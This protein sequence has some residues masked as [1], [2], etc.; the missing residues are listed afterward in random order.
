MPA[1][2]EGASRRELEAKAEPTAAATN[3][4]T[5]IA[6]ANAAPLLVLPLRCMPRWC[7]RGCVRGS[8]ASV[9]EEAGQLVLILHLGSCLCLLLVQC[10]HHEGLLG[11]QGSQEAVVQA[12]PAVAAAA[13]G[14][15]GG[16]WVGVGV[17][18]LGD[19]DCSSAVGP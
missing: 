6:T 16:R 3:R 10:L 4:R 18:G 5:T 9:S 8:V 13:V 2:P 7:G 17:G 11:L 19:I 15:G 12:A 14:G 1:I